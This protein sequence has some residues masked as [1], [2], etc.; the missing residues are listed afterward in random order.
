MLIGCG[1]GFVEW[2]IQ[3]PDVSSGSNGAVERASDGVA[4]TGRVLLERKPRRDLRP[5]ASVH[6][7][8]HP[9][10]AAPAAFGAVEP[11]RR[12]VDRESGLPRCAKDVQAVSPEDDGS[13]GR[14]GRHDRVR[15]SAGERRCS[16]R[17]RHPGQAGAAGAPRP[18]AATDVRLRRQGPNSPDLWPLSDR[19]CDQPQEAVG[20]QA[21][22]G[23]ITTGPAAAK[24]PVSR[25]ATVK[26]LAAAMAAM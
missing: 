21:C 19:R 18:A 1:R 17:L 23:L 11:G 5:G 24:G 6:H 13:S 9:P 7:L 2:S 25:V 3:V 22:Q 10:G 14:Q 8:R 15:G 16:L 20:L 26:P 12:R 4:R